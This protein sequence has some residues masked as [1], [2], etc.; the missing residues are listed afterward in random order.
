MSE[1]L[2]AFAKE[3]EECFPE[4]EYLIDERL[5]RFAYRIMKRFY[6]QDAG[7]VAFKAG[8]RRDIANWLHAQLDKPERLTEDI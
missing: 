7:Y 2:Q 6:A 8:E 1:M 4:G 5:V 3:A